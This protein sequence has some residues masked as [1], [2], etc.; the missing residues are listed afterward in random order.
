MAGASDKRGA[1]SNDDMRHACPMNEAIA[2]RT[3]RVHDVAAIQAVEVD[4]G[5]RFRD[6]AMA[7]VAE[8]KPPDGRLLR[9]YIDGDQLWVATH[10]RDVVGY[11]MAQRIDDHAHV[12]QVSVI[13]RFAGQ[14]IGAT[15]LQTA[16]DWAHA[17]GAHQL[18]LFTF[19]NV[20]W[21]A[22]YYRRL[23]FVD[24]DPESIGP[25]LKKIWD[26]ELLTDLPDWNRIVL[27]RTPVSVG[28]HP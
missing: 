18:T 8:D 1:L 17:Q 9:R 13:R 25:G 7:P 21:N 27:A 23:G 20:P 14:R 19:E 5:Q 28:F 10:G 22:P 16:G 2:F 15:L 6:V 4:A 24:V 26:L 3:G 12:D 11:A